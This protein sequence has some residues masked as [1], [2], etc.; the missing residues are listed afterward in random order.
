[1]MSHVAD[2]A[3]FFS[4]SAREVAWTGRP[5]RHCARLA[6]L[7]LA[8]TALSAQTARGGELPTSGT[9][10]SGS[11]AISAPS[12]TSVL[13][14]Q[15]SRN[16][17]INW[18]SFSVG[19]G[20]TVRFENGSGATLNRVTG[21][22][23]SRIDGSLS[24]TGSVYLVNPNGIT[25]GPTG[26]VMTGG[27]FI[28]STHD[29]SDAE[30]N[31]GGAMTFKG[32]STASVINYGSIGSLG[33]DVALIARKVENAGTITAPNGTVGLA[34]GY[35]VLVRDAALSNGKFVVKV[36]GG[37]TE[38]KTTGVI[39]AAE[40]ELKANGGNVYALAG[41][42]DSVTKA[43][44]VSNRGGRIFLT[45][46]DGG[47]VHV[48]QKLSAQVPVATGKAKGGEIRASG[49]TVKTSGR[50]DARGEGDAGGTIVVT[51]RDIALASGADLDASGATGGLVLVGGD[52]Q[53]GRDATTKY[54][55]EDV[56]T[57]TSTI[58]EAGAGIRADGAAGAGGRI[59]VW[60]NET[61]S[62]AGAISATGAGV[63]SGGDAEVSGK[64]RLAY[65]GTADLRSESGAFGTLLLDPYNLTI[66]SASSSGMSGFSANDDDS[67]LNVT[68]LQNALATAN[69]TVTTGSGGSQAGDITVASAVAWSANSTLTLNAANNIAIAA[70]I[71][72]TGANAGLVLNYGGY[73][74]SGS[75]A[76]GTDYSVARSA[77]VTLSGTNASL[78]VNGSGY[79]L[80][81]SISDLN[82]VGTSGAYA[83]MA[84][85]EL[86]DTPYT[87]SVI[88]PEGNDTTGFSGTFAGFGH[89]ISNL[90]ISKTSDSS[91]RNIGLFSNVSGAVRDF[92]LVSAAIN[93][94][95]SVTGFGY[96]VGLLAGSMSDAVL[97]N[98]YA[99]GSVSVNS[100]GASA[101]V[102]GLVG[103]LQR[104]V[105]VSNVNADVSVTA[106]SS[107]NTVGVGGL[108]GYAQ[109]STILNA[110]ASGTVAGEGNWILR[111]GGLVGSLSG[112]TLRD[113]YATS[114]VTVSGGASG[115]DTL[116]SVGG[117]VGR[118]SNQAITNV[119]ATGHVIMSGSGYT[120]G[121]VG[122]GNLLTMSS[123][124][125]DKDATGQ[126]RGVGDG[127]STGFTGLTTAQMQDGSSTGTGFYALASAAGWDF[128]TVWARPNSMASQ[129]SDGQLHYAEL[130]SVSRVVGVTVAGNMTYGDASPNLTIVYYGTGGAYGNRIATAPTATSSVTSSND[131]GTYAASAS[132]GSGA[133]SGGQTARLVY[134]PGSVTVSPA[135]LTVTANGGSMVY[136]DAAPALGYT[137]SGWKNGQGDSL[138]SGVT[139]TTSATS[140]SNV[141]TTYTSSASGG[142]LSGA[143]AGNYTLTYADGGFSVTPRALT[144]TADA[145]SM[146]YGDGV[147]AL[148]YA[149]GGAGLV[150]GDVLSGGLAT[151][152][153]SASSAGSYA[154]A[155]G[156]L[157]ASSN[158]ALTYVGA[159]LAVV[160]RLL[161][162]VADAQSIMYGEAVPALTYA[163]GG[164]G[165]VNGDS[166]TGALAAAA[167]S[168]SNVGTYAITLGT[169][170]ASPNYAIAYTGANLSVTPRS[171]TVTAD[172]QSMVYGDG[173]AGL[174]YAVGGAGLVNGDALSGALATAASP[175]SRV[176]SYAITQGTLAASSNY[177][178]TYTGANVSITARAITIAAEAQSMV[179]GD[180][181]PGLTYG[182]GGA[183]LVNGDA[184]S[185]ALATAAGSA[186]D[187][188]SYAITQGTL[189]ASANYVLTYVGSGLTVAPRPLTVIAADQTR[190]AGLPNPALTYALGG[191]GLVHGD[192]LTGA[193][194]TSAGPL[195]GTGT[196]PI[197]QG[198]L[199][200]TSNYALTY[201]PGTLTVVASGQTPAFIETQAQDEVGTSRATE[202]LLELVDQA[203]QF[204]S[205][206]AIVSCDSG[207]GGACSLLPVPD[208]RSAGPFLSFRAF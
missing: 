19:A 130:Y 6:V 17:I 75:I 146:A 35:E 12:A 87:S 196:Y 205:P 113:S 154:I 102:G 110:Y 56:K 109:N 195:S 72:A 107:T 20:N 48:T 88:V 92:G 89:T 127:T 65:D 86:S 112:G 79:T 28:A 116:Q 120:G 74:T 94:G 176:G 182:V 192:T 187:V 186:S 40:A 151:A 66:S 55:A 5:A 100:S 59:V 18:G 121:L 73:A 98:V 58:V 16:A 78:E 162:I 126:T 128:T 61:T 153:S 124:F 37:D 111:A 123:S 90:M 190:A 103:I 206:P 155:Q 15:T 64:A 13:V 42:T 34:A 106:E 85:L 141:G 50:L 91:Y 188:G 145:Q 200:A 8:A 131:V 194:A 199:A 2:V 105:N 27:S 46:G 29:V 26:Q 118:A 169:L 203:P 122:N 189:D 132:G 96:N 161:T 135:T 25:V 57:A 45:A 14:T 165:L 53:G 77:S 3:R 159:N 62:F 129:S 191:R 185:G 207:V 47:L 67:V 21:L 133:T 183:G 31:A 175:T 117:L 101:S 198:S 52:Y 119:Y 70:N 51:A 144:V 184:L 170:G 139:V 83:L 114:N 180:S 204:Q 41:N 163:V 150:N 49:G 108:F 84:N 23:P 93:V 104:D 11:A 208:N 76:S 181:V 54:L 36:G 160:P 171:L 68:T 32:S 38:A 7:L 9:V 193:L 173:V 33:G 156:T 30:F 136:G 39:K 179:Y 22:S 43:T 63:A 24:A 140:T 69:V 164:A 138:L 167:T 201:I 149:V 97:K 166:L 148:T 95:V 71:T 143:A 137:G 152:A 82:A 177:A 202:Q 60:S 81:R 80:I 115:D 174:T 4:A 197:T 1:M 147:P 99:T 134:Y 172:A 158:Y 178:V 168:G 142:T 44:G 125:Y 10:V 157:A